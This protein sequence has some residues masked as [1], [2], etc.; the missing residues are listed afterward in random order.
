[1]T[2]I[3]QLSDLHLGTEPR[4]QER[5]ERVVGYLASHP[6]ALDPKVY[7][8]DHL[9]VVIGLDVRSGLRG[10]HGE[11][12]GMVTLGL[13]PDPGNGHEGRALQHR[14]GIQRLRRRTDVGFESDHVLN[15]QFVSIIFRNIF[16]SAGKGG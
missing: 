15:P 12:G 3:A 16:A 10:Q 8:I 2:T 4:H 5:F 11:R 13:A 9:P 1:M 14:R 7:L 6:I